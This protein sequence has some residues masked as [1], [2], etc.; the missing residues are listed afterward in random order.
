[1]KF[2][3]TFTTTPISKKQLNNLKVIIKGRELEARTIIRKK[4]NKLAGVERHNAQIAMIKFGARTRLYLLAYAFLRGVAYNT[5]EKKVHDPMMC[6]A[7]QAE[8]IVK[9]CLFVVNNAYM[10]GKNSGKELT[11]T[12]ILEWLKGKNTYFV[13]NELKTVKTEDK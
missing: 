11:A 13:V 3:R 7:R 12:H 5:V 10:I 8:E 6:W 4:I 9:I 1:M 2:E